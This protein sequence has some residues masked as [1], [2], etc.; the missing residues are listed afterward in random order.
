FIRE[1][2]EVAIARKAATDATPA[3]ITI[4]RDNIEDQERRARAGDHIG[5]LR[6]DEA[7]HEALAHSADCDHAWR[8]LEGL[9]AQ[10][11]RVR[12]LSMPDATPIETLIAQH[13]AIVD[14]IDS[15]SPETAEAAV[16]V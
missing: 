5:F 12:W 3:Q 8:V 10:M 6:L 7:F 15:R 4:L 9:K 2:I 11:D 1:A 14:A 13:K 16:H